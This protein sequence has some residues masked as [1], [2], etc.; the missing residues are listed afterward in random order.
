M[1]VK[2]V[3]NFDL[4]FLSDTDTSWAHRRRA[5]KIVHSSKTNSG[6]RQ[7]ESISNKHLLLDILTLITIII[8][9]SFT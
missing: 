8:N 4:G 9:A 2:Q 5:E 3:L 1:R 6:A 7:L